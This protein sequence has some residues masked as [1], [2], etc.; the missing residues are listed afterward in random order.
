MGSGQINL[1]RQGSGRP[2]LVL[3]A[4]GGSGVWNPYLERLS[5]HFDVLAPDH[6]GFGLSD[7]LLEIQTMADLVQHYVTLLDELGI[8]RLDVVGASFGGWIAAEIASTI[9]ERVEH[10]VLQ[11]PAGLHIPEARPTCSPWLR[12][13]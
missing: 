12:R 8:D 7:E 4:A 1:F 13:T 3:H 11:A 9:P 2:V 6:P 10:L 5:E